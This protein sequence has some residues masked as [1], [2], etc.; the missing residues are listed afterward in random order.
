MRRRGDA[1]TAATALAAGAPLGA[2]GL[3]LEVIQ[4]VPGLR[5]QARGGSPR[6]GALSAD[7]TAARAAIAAVHTNRRIALG[8]AVPADGSVGHVVVAVLAGR[9]LGLVPLGAGKAEVIFS[10]FGLG[11]DVHDV[12][13][14]LRGLLPEPDSAYILK[15]IKER[16]Q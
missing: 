12:R 5:G 13:S 8:A 6:G 10:V 7:P 14:D 2:R 16:L 1:G 9:A 3:L 15:K 4:V 11:D